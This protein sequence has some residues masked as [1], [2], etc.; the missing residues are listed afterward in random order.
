MP[1]RPKRR[2]EP[3]RNGCIA[4]RLKFLTKKTNSANL[5]EPTEV[6]CVDAVSARITCWQWI[7][8]SGRMA[9]SGSTWAYLANRR[10]SNLRM[11]GKSDV[12]QKHESHNRRHHRWNERCACSATRGLRPTVVTGIAV[13]V[14]ELCGVS[15]RTKFDLQRMQTAKP[16]GDRG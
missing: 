6:M 14:F 11:G 1:D 8:I 15:P 13:P 2:L 7:A 5:S 4:N 3:L 12:A 9:N 16:C 10:S